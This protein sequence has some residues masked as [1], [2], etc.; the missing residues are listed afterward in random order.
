LSAQWAAACGVSLALGAPVGLAVD[1]TGADWQDYGNGF[2]QNHFSPL[3]LIDRTNV[4]MLKLTWHHDLDTGQRTDS[5]PLA[6][7]GVVYVATG[8]S[9]VRALD[10]KTGALLW[11]YDPG[12][13][14]VAGVKLRSGWGT[15][16]LTYGAGRL[17]LGTMDGRLI[18]LDAHTGKVAWSFETITKDSEATITGAP[19]FFKNKVL[20][21]F[22]GGDRSGARG[23]VNC[24]DAATGKHLW[25]FYT[26]PGNP[27]SLF[28]ND[29]MR[30]AATTWTGEWWKNGGGGVVWNAMTYDPDFNRVYIGTG[31]AD[32]WNPAIRNPEG[33]DNL[34]TSSIVALDADTGE[35]RWHYQENPNDE[36]DYDSVNDL[37][38]ATL[39]I[40]GEKRRVLMHAPKN[41]FFYVLDRKDGRLISAEKLDKVTWAERIDL[42]TGRPVELANGRYGQRAVL[43]WPSFY[44]V[45][46]FPPMSFDA[47]SRI[48][49]IPTIHMAMVYDGR[50]VD[51]KK[52]TAE[53]NTW[54]SGLST[55][56]ADPSI[57]VPSNEFGSAL[58][59]WDPVNQKKL[60]SAPTAGTWGGGVMSTAGGL[61]FQGQVDGTFAAYDTRNGKKVW[62]F[63]AGDSVTGSPMAYK[64]GGKEYVTVMSGPLVGTPSAVGQ[65]ATFGWRYGDPRRVL[66]FA[67]NGEDSL[68]A[69]E[70]PA[71][72]PVA[73]T[74][75]IDGSTADRG[76]GLYATHCQHCHGAVAVSGAAAP[77]LRYSAIIISK[78]AMFS[79]VNGGALETRGMPKFGE[80][81]TADVD[82]IRNYVRCQANAGSSTAATIACP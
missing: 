50:D 54:T 58:L 76:A 66:T 10:G 47:Q 5:Q 35:Y 16:G 71:Q 39:S 33:K 20:I 28:E 4:T 79:V 70:R 42:K 14:Q 9:V 78:D 68:P 6:I 24:Y 3:K 80:L 12:V 34:Y 44:G 75:P 40:G 17:Y 41:G 67:L 45:H 27:A 43:V 74:E 13:A 72:V 11:R 29:A 48:M 18:A 21:G 49:F 15:R 1:R 81:S 60:W 73:S 56:P 51:P 32:A 59:A 38:L 77:D 82:D 69:V 23:A 22:A 65:N 53:K 63:N 2:A 37:E 30:R 25:R 57:E 55:E 7:D 36:W 46:N 8:L 31:N 26:V 64:I 61:V 52:W 19:L 62:S